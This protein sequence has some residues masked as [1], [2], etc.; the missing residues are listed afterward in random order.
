MDTR[1]A[2]AR[3]AYYNQTFVGKTL[4]SLQFYQAN[5]NYVE[6][7][8]GQSWLIDGG[9]TL[10]FTDG[11]RLTM[12]W[13]MEVNLMRLS[14]D[15][16]QKMG[17]DLELRELKALAE[18]PNLKALVGKKVTDLQFTWGEF[19]LVL[20]EE[21]KIRTEA[22]P[23]VLI[24]TF[25]SGTSLVLAAVNMEITDDSANVVELDLEGELLVSVD[26]ALLAMFH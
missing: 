21:D 5:D 6:L 18:T 9:A 12:G 10:N 26:Q 16:M 8:E 3:E 15:T 14:E 20:E 22:A 19:E 24:V 13:S 2:E 7:Y 25:S 17:K 23:Y 4:D 1:K 11:A